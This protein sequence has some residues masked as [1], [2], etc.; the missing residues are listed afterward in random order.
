[1]T[2]SPQGTSEEEHEYR[3]VGWAGGGVLA[4]VRLTLL[5]WPLEHLL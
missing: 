4:M 5:C 3:E 1:M 2:K